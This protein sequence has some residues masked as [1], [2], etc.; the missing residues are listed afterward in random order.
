MLSIA[1]LAV[2]YLI[3][4]KLGLELALVNSY[5]TAVWPATGIALAAILLR[6][7]KIWP[8]VFIGAFL[9]N[10]LVLA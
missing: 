7:Y 9:A 2:V 3:G 10:H 4:A 1:V 6:G 8:G 5:A